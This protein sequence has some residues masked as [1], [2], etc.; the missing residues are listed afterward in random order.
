MDNMT[1]REEHTTREAVPKMGT[2]A[3]I[4]GTELEMVPLAEALF[5]RTRRAILGLLFSHPDESFYLRQM[6]RLLGLGHGALQRELRGLAAA[7]ILVRERNGQQIL[8][9]VN[10][11]CP[12]YNDLSNLIAK[13]VGLADVLRAA[14]AALGERI[15]LAFVYGSLAKGTSKAGSDVDIMVIGFA[16]FSEIVAALSPLQ[17]TLR[18]EISPSVYPPA[19]FRRKIRD[20]SHFV[21]TVLGE[22]KI[23]LMGDEDELERLAKA[24]V[25]D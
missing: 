4:L 14:L 12:I 24:G 17:D 16:S 22:P 3:P 8:Y 21:T 10:R 6:A 7:G 20:G 9:R 5:G 18:R 23:M 25:A 1:A 11:F 2:T 13:T 19:E 15:D